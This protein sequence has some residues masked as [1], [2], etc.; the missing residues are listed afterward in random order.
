MKTSLSYDFK[1]KESER[2]KRKCRGEERL[3][4]WKACDQR[5]YLI[6]LDIFY[7]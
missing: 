6:S 2:K 1:K 3:L 5:T 7:T 4:P